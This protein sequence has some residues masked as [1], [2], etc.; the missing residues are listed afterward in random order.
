MMLLTQG[1]KS[2]NTALN[3]ILMPRYVA[4]AVLTYYNI[5]MKYAILRVFEYQVQ[6]TEVTISYTSL[7]FIWGWGRTVN[8][9]T[10]KDHM[11]MDN[12]IL[13]I[14]C[15]NWAPYIQRDGSGAK[16]SKKK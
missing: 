12:S 13:V 10:E 11:I 15:F 14:I 5:M 2:V 16:L 3:G 6:S 7:M 9:K 4:C 8:R 1:A